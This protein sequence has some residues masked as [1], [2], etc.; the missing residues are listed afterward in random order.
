MNVSG[1][2]TSSVQ[3]NTEARVTVEKQYYIC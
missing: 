1:N 2:K 3:C